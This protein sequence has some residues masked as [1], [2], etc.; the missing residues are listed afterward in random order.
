MG[1]LLGPL[2]V[3][4]IFRNNKAS[5]GAGVDSEGRCRL[6][7]QTPNEELEITPVRSPSSSQAVKGKSDGFPPPTRSQRRH[8]NGTAPV[9][10]SSP[11][12]IP[13]PVLFFGLHLALLFIARNE[14]FGLRPSLAAISRCFVATKRRSP[15]VSI[16]N[17]QISIRLLS[18]WRRNEI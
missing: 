16:L 18:I 9:T 7:R 4:I 11:S 1:Y 3:P 8:G 14:S 12:L 5:T 17:P 15:P 10:F 2:W 6:H 13:F